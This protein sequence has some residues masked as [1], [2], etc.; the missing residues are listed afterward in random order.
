[1]TLSRLLFAPV[2]SPRQLRAEVP[3]ELARVAMR[4]LGRDRSARYRDAAAALGALEACRAR[5]RAEREQLAALLAER[6]RERPPVI[7][8]GSTVGTERL[9]GPL[10]ARRVSRRRFA[11]ALVACAALGIAAGLA[12]GIRA[13]Q[14]E[15]AASSIA[16]IS[17]RT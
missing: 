15:A 16:A 14:H 13:T 10:D 12:L 5:D 17:T 4:L 1:E 3:E 7:A 2:P 9:P 8:R 6:L 11:L